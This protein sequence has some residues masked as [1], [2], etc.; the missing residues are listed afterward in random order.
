MPRRPFP[1]LR[2]GIAYY[3][4]Q[5]ALELNIRH[6]I[7]LISFSRQYPALLFPG[8][9]QFGQD[10]PP[11][12]LAAETL[13]DSINPVSWLY[14]GRRIT[15]IAPDLTVVHW[16]HPFFSPCLGIA[17]RRAAR[18]SRNRVLFIC[19]NVVPHEPFPLARGLSRFALTAGD[20]WL[21]HSES[22]RRALQSLNLRATPWL[23]PNLRGKDSANRST[24]RRPRNALV[25]RG[26]FYSSS[27]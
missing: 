7:V 19:H 18:R 4:A 27:A 23:S 1:P 25:L 2:G 9:T 13:L 22:D 5:L 17:L 21:V 10:P 15:E 3:N 6:E 16:W 12:R 14:A 20:A 11:Q 24:K 26:R 8:R